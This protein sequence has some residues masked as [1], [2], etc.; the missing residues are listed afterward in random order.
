[1]SNEIKAEDLIVT[2]QDGTRRVDHELLKEVG[3]F[4]LPKPVLRSALMVYYEN[5]KRQNQQAAQTVRTLI[6]ITNAI[7]RFPKEIAVNFTRGPAYHRNMKLL[8]RFSR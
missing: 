2:A 4:N 3:L 6:N 1:M 8:G 7:E 5:A